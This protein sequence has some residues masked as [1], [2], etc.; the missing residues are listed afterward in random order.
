MYLRNSIILR[1]FTITIKKQATKWKEE[2]QDPLAVQVAQYE[3]MK[4]LLL[5]MFSKFFY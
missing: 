2:F 3:E 1:F 5:F 4:V